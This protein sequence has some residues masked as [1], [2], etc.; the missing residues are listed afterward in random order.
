MATLRSR[1]HAPSVSTVVV[2]L[3][4]GIALAVTGS[5][6]D[7]VTAVTPAAAPI[8]EARLASAPGPAGPLSTVAAVSAM[9]VVHGGDSSVTG[10]LAA[11]Y[12]PPSALPYA[13]AGTVIRSQAIAAGPGLPAGTR[14][15]R[16]LFHTTSASG[17][18]LAESGV[19]VVPGGSPPPGGFP[20]VS[21]AHGT[22]GVASGCAPSVDGT[23]TIPD[24]AALLAD[25]EIVVAADYRGLG[26]PGL[27]PYLVGDSEAEDVLDGARAARSLVGASA[28]NAVVILGYSQGGQAALFAGEIAQSYA[29]E[30][31]VAGVA[32]VAPVTSVLELAPTGDQPPPSGQSAFTAMALFAWARHYRTFALQQVL[33]PAGLAGIPAVSSSCVDGVALLYDAVPPARFF[34]PGW[35]RQPAV[36]AANRANRPGGSPTSA[37]ILVVQGTADRVVP[38]GQTTSFVGRRLCR[39]QYDTVD[40]VTEPGVGHGH[41]LDQSI[42]VINRWVRSRFSGT[43]TVDSCTRPGLG[44]N[45]S[46]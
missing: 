12:R 3:L 18:D 40:Y 2:V 1:A 24:L 31:F 34:L 38:F 10:T 27:H 4:L 44:I 39:A 46:G 26:T 45:R 29:P 11:F 16:V 21:W 14:A 8:S 6:A 19:V 20:I 43:S 33:T 5:P 7:P 42:P 41:V 9:A 22:T 32:A 13:P 30:L 28:S 35:Q 15:W 17:G 37:P 36:Q 25:G 23:A